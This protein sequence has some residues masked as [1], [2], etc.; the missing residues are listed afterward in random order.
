M[1][2]LSLVNM[3]FAN[4]CA[5]SL[6]LSQLAAVVATE[7]GEGV[8]TDVLYLNQEFALF[9]GREMYDSLTEDLSHL[10]SGLGDWLFRQVA[11]SHEPDN[12]DEY[13]RRF[14]A[15]TRNARWRGFISERRPAIAQWC[16]EVV[17]RHS[18]VT[19][20]AVGFTSMFQQTAPSIAIA[21]LIKAANP[22][23][24]TMMGGANCE[25]PMGATI[26]KHVG[27]LDFVM[28]GPALRTLPK[29]LTRLRDDGPVDDIP[30]VLTR[31]N[32][33]DERFRRSVGEDRPIGDIV[34]PDFS[35]FRSSFDSYRAAAHC[36]SDEPTLYVETSR[37][38]WWG[39]RSHCTF[40]GLNGGGMAYRSMSADTALTALENAF[41][42]Y[43]WCRNYLAVDNIM[44]MEF[45][46]EV[47]P[48]LRTPAGVSLFYEVKA[49]LDRQDMATLRAAGVSVIQPG[50]ES[51][52]TATLKLM[53]KGTSAFRNVSF[54]KNCAAAGITPEW[55]LLIGFPGED[56]A[57][58][59][60]Y[61]TDIPLMRHLPPP[62]GA[63]LVR[64]DRYSPYF[65]NAAEYGLELRPSDHYRYIYPFDEDALASLAY[66]FADHSLSPY[67]FKAARW[68]KPL[69]AL[70][71]DWRRRWQDKETRP[72]L[73]LVRYGG[74]PHVVD[75]RSGTVT[76]FALDDAQLRL[77]RELE[78]SRRIA[79]VTRDAAASAAFL[80]LLAR[81]VLFV[82]G[83]RAISLVETD[84]GVDPMPRAGRGDRVS[85]PEPSLVALTA[86][87]PA[88]G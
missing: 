1:F 76:E 33:D 88:E 5:P 85:R 72:V 28:S 7:L 69:N 57:T 39:E 25:T 60:K 70:I 11:F 37:G 6:A 80:A 74:R 75:S 22:A 54:L 13:L 41:K 68:G 27:S 20:D 53:R 2:R 64:Y 87:P 38:C 14:Y 52:S 23:V 19:A 3:P 86:R 35:A 29:L 49:N 32:C 55:N 46:S 24:V 16:A 4:R 44:P 8:E 79:E 9:F 67:L 40:C 42:H 77:V 47:F 56:E 18:L 78:R 58:Y 17:E 36:E 31:R 84:F 34:I 71:E 73:R 26:V 66:Y 43:P 65:E 81:S 30:G 51:M 61:S 62:A 50:I 12:V 83:D 82:E 63:Y 15:G 45:L 21:N 59:E 10:T 48:R